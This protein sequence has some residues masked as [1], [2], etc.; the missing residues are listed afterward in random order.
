VERLRTALSG[1][2]HQPRRVTFDLRD[3]TFVDVAGLAAISES[4]EFLVAGGYRVSVLPSAPVTWLLGKLD[5]AGCPMTIGDI[6][7]APS[8]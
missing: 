6:G 1:I 3:V 7:E 4:V 8:P 2:N 5:A